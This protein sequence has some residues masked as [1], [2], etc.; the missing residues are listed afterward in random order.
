VAVAL[1]C[2]LA[3][4][5][6][7]GD[8]S[9]RTL[10]GV[11]S[12]WR[13]VQLMVDRA[14]APLEFKVQWREPRCR[15]GPMG[16]AWET[17]LLSPWDRSGGGRFSERVRQVDASYP[18][19]VVVVDIRV[20]GRRVSAGRWRG[21]FR[22]SA[23]LL[24]RGETVRRC[25]RELTWRAGLHKASLTVSGEPYEFI[26][27]GLQWS[28]SQLD[29]DV[30]AWVDKTWLQI[31]FDGDDSVVWTVDLRPPRGFRERPRKPPPAGVSGDGR[32]CGYG[33]S[34]KLTSLRLDR[35]GLPRA[36]SARITQRCGADAPA[37]TAELTFRRGW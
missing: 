36:L 2:L 20:R 1:G 12:Q 24:K 8:P 37:L 21:T 6:A 19:Y 33:G 17:D 14:G 16:L 15:L 13:P 27:G 10:E 25:R 22:V 9:Y 23:R 34:F 30:T 4:A 35:R 5:S 3:P 29:S 26:T 11:T 18:P 31:E 28:Y 7:V 32:S